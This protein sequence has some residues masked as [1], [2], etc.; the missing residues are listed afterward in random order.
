MKEQIRQ[1]IAESPDKLRARNLVREYCQAR[2]LQFL[3]DRGVFR[4]WVFHGGTALRFLYRLPRYSEDLDFALIGPATRLD[5][6][7]IIANVRGAFEAEAYN[8]SANIRDRKTVKSASIRFPGLLHELGI[9]PRPTEALSIKI[10]L[11]SHP[12]LGGKTE[13]SLLR[14]FALLNVLH[15]DRASFLSGK[16]HAILARP[17]VKGRDLYDLLWYLSDRSWP[18]PNI[19]FLDSAL[20]QTHWKGPEITKSNWP[21]LL[22]GR[23]H[24][25]DWKRAVEDVRPFIERLPDL[26]LLTRENVLSLLKAR[27]L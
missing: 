15:Y 8:A 1:I 13:T 9:S 7:D 4:S 10:E 24:E 17:Y 5:F 22:A 16:L 3:Q 14:R 12:P 21:T 23:I 19:R 6:A 26:G 2:I 18:E 11:D 27:L 20:K 25:V